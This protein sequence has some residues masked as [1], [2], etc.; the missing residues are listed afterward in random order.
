MEHSEIRRS[1]VLGFVARV[2][3]EAG[4]A[5]V[6]LFDLGSVAVDKIG[7]AFKKAPD[8]LVKSSETKIIKD[9]IKKKEDKIEKLYSEI[10]KEGVK[11]SGADA[12]SPLETKIVKNLISDV[13]EYEK[14]V[15]RL[16]G[17]ISEVKEE[18]KAETLRKRE[19]K[20]EAMPAKEKAA[21]KDVPVVKAVKSEIENALRDGVFES[22]SEKA[23]FEKVANDLLDSDM[24]VK[25][26]AVTE[27]AKMKNKAAVPVL[28]ETVKFEEPH[29]VSEIVNALIDI[30][31]SKAVPLFKEK[32]T[33]PHYRV[34]VASLRGLYK[35]AEDDDEEATQLLTNAL[36]DEHADVRRSAITFIGWKDN[37]D[38]VPALVQCLKDENE[39]VR[40][41]ALSALATIR[42]KS[43]V[44]PL[45]RALKDKG[46]DMKEKALDAIKMITGEEITFD[47]EASGKELSKAIDDLMDWWQKKRLGEVEIA[48]PEAV[49]TAEEAEEAEEAEPVVELPSEAD[50]KRKLKSE[51][52]SICKDLG[53]ECDE[54]LTKSELIEL[55]FENSEKN[56]KRKL[57]SELI[58]ICKDLGIEAD[59]EL[60]KSELIQ[61]ILERKE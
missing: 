13:R 39:K 11:Y 6:D 15:R 40:K 55:I 10:G 28:T 43:A 49:E 24:E 12:E 56:L 31:D 50:L 46:L 18:E 21:I 58:S 1:G 37:V 14:E 47:L 29:L 33:D 44:V 7:S 51:L 59:E 4:G 41:A 52:I 17:R 53:I 61:L 27:L 60:T 30:G 48:Q 9:K 45:I 42:E 34:R 32:G 5:F 36:Q 8:L 20:E 54:E 3:N 2:L 23:K 38:A 25:I 19:L 16:K 35:L 57:K 26:L 22:T